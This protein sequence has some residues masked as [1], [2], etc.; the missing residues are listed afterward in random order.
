[1]KYLIESE[2]FDEKIRS[3]YI[4]ESAQGEVELSDE[5]VATLVRLMQEKK[6]SDVEQLNLEESEPEIYGKL[7]EVCY[8][9]CENAAY[10][11][12]LLESYWAA[13][14]GADGG[15]TT[16]YDMDDIKYY[17]EEHC[18][19]SYDGDEADDD[20]EEKKEDAFY[21]WLDRYLHTAPDKDVLTFFQDN[22]EILIEEY[23]FLEPGSVYF[24]VFDVIPQSIIDMAFPKK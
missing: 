21:K 7:H 12:A 24:K 23:E 6:S 8:E 15:G 4:I 20:Y 14:T 2:Q 11:Y 22:I 17:C 10:D 13:W 16:D 9:L 19:F 1:M 3:G 18:G 5:E